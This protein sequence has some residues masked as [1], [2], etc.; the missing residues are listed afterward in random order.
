[1]SSTVHPRRFSVSVL[2][3]SN[4]SIVLPDFDVHTQLT[5]N[6]FS[7]KVNC[8]CVARAV[9][10]MPRTVKLV[11]VMFH[12]FDAIDYLLLFFV[13]TNSLAVIRWAV[14]AAIESVELFD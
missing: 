1:M 12:A 4:I 6:P 2:R 7:M 5:F 9:A 10:F 11:A 13:A 8:C 14:F 3:L